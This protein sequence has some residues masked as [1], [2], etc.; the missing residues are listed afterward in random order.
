MRVSKLPAEKK[1]VKKIKCLSCGIE[2]EE[3]Y[4]EWDKNICN[5]CNKCNK[6]IENEEKINKIYRYAGFYPIHKKMKIENLDDSKKDM[7]MKFKDENLFIYGNA[8]RGKTFYAVARLFEYMSNGL[9]G[10][11]I[12]VP[13]L[14]NKLRLLS[15]NGQDIEYLQHLSELDTLVI[16][17]LCVG[18]QNDYVIE[19]IYLL[20]DRWC[21]NEKKRMIITSNISLDKIGE[22][23]DDRISSRIAGMCK[24]I[25]LE[26]KDRRVF[27]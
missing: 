17:D 2:F 22:I 1:I 27:T 26:G 6:M 21:R 4:F 16:D 23:I 13:E 19:Q 12:I 25:K 5:Y 8:G 7:L 10:K 18:R 20:I 24:I 3:H 14:I 9:K 11:L 15:K